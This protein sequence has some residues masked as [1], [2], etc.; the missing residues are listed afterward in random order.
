MM[1]GGIVG[2]GPAPPAP[3]GSP[4]GAGSR[5]GLGNFQPA[6]PGRIHSAATLAWWVLL[7][8]VRPPYKTT[9]PA[10]GWQLPVTAGRAFPPARGTGP[11][12]QRIDR[13]VAVHDQASPPGRKGQGPRGN[14]DTRRFASLRCTRAATFTLRHWAR[15]AADRVSMCARR[16]SRRIRRGA[17]LNCLLALMAPPLRLPRRRGNQMAPRSF[18]AT[19]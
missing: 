15:P 2:H 6:L 13:R 19:T 12:S 4:P 16:S 8:S 11:S 9:K 14:T 1:P 18:M 17:N 10:R 5:A 3:G 7:L